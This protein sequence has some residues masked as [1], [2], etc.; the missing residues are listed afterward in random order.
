MRCHVIISK[1]LKNVKFFEEKL[2][3]DQFAFSSTK[4]LSNILLKWSSHQVLWFNQTIDENERQCVYRSEFILFGLYV[5]IRFFVSQFV[6]LFIFP[7]NDIR[8]GKKCIE[9]KAFDLKHY[10]LLEMA[11]VYGIKFH[12]PVPSH[13]TVMKRTK[14]VGYQCFE[15]M[16]IIA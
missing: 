13:S 15:L 2:D 14:G 1:L 12:C 4:P 7:N 11:N 6:F 5:N 9:W 16:Y 10:N 8:S 3:F